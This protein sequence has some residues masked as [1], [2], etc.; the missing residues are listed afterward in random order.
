M[1][2]KVMWA[3]LVLLLLVVVGVCIV[4]FATREPDVIQGVLI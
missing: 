2:A 3:G 1:K 4:Y